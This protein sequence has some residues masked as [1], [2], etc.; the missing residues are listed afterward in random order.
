MVIRNQTPL[1]IPEAEEIFDNSKSAKDLKPFFK[2][3][4]ILKAG[5]A[6][7][8]KEKLESSN[9]IKLRADLIVKICDILPRDMEDL[10]KIFGDIGL[11][12][13][14]ADKILAIVKEFL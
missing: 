1:S 4:G 6:K 12:K 8:L 9:I 14:E 3:F 2:T 11:D 10:N 13:D 5:D 7:K